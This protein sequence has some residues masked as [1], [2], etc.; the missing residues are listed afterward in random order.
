MAMEQAKKSSDK[1]AVEAAMKSAADQA[2]IELGFDSQE[3][4][5]LLISDSW[6]AVNKKGESKVEAGEKEGE[7]V[8][9]AVKK[10]EHT[11]KSGG[12]FGGMFGSSSSK[13]GGYAA[14][15]GG[16]KDAESS[17]KGGAA[18]EKGST[19]KQF[20]IPETFTEMVRLNAAMTGANLGFVNIMLDEFN[21]LVLD[22]CRLGQLQEQ[23]DILAMRIAKDTKGQVKTSEFKVCMLAAMR[24]LI[25]QRWD[26]QHEKA[27]A[28]LWDSIDTQLKLSMPLPNKYEVPVQNYVA[29]MSEAELGDIGLKVW[30]RMF[31][32]EPKVEDVFKQ[33][34]ERLKWIAVQAMLY[35]AKIYGNPTEMNAQ[36]QAL[37]LKHIMF[38]VNPAY[39]ALFVECIDEEIKERC[40]DPNVTNGM[41][42]SLTI[43]ACIL[44]RGVESGSTP[45]LMAALNNNVKTLKSEMARIPRGQRGMAML[46]A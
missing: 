40:D 33:S 39:F 27:W 36:M 35:S 15:K 10:T 14:A 41:N 34:N 28:W 25:P 42:W 32:K 1:D 29:A 19:D 43:I 7:E 5:L 12:W 2:V 31:A 20:D 23:T 4:V 46:S 30:Y 6:D 24:S 44:A 8:K 38:K 9:A 22:T 18:A 21:N 37:S 17:G 13:P 3:A 45:L 16:A 11:A 26:T